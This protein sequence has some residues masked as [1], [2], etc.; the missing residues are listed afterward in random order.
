MPGWGCEIFRVV[1]LE[2]QGV[3]ANHLGAD[4]QD[5]I[6]RH[7]LGI[8]SAARALAVPWLCSEGYR[9]LPSALESFR[10]WLPEY[11]TKEIAMDP[12]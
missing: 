7:F 12:C 9:K 4:P 10:A 5:E 6:Q 11:R 8:I 2:Q 3:R 1:S